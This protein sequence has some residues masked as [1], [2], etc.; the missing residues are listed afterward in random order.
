MPVNNKTAN[1]K[2]PDCEQLRLDKQLC[3]PLYVCS[4]EVIR[5]YKP[6]L[7]EIGL[8]YTQYLVM[9]V[10]WEAGDHTVKELGTRLYLDSGTLTPLLKKMEQTGL[11]N[12][13]RDEMDIRSVIVSLTAKGRELREKAAEIPA[14]IGTCVGISEQEAQELYRLL[15]R[16]MDSL[17]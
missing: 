15:Y 10:L 4:K 16:V 2:M 1:S 7:D 13:E 3:F 6:F 11:V 14:K 8:T 9:L 5:R 17:Q 12:R